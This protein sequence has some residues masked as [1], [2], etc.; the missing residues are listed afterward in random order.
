[1]FDILQTSMSSVVSYQM[2]IG[3]ENLPAN[4]TNVTLALVNV[5]VAFQAGFVLI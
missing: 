3:A 5:N 4:F 1:M 2:L